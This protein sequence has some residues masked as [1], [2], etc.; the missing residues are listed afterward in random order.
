M[1]VRS[2]G[3]RVLRLLSL[4]AC[5]SFAPQ[6]SRALPDE[7]PPPAFAGTKVGQVRDDNRLGMKLIWCPAGR[8]KMGT[9]ADQPR[10]RTQDERQ[11]DVTFASGFWLGSTELTQAQWELVM[12]STPW[13]GKKVKVKE[14]DEYPAVYVSWDEAVAYCE[15]LTDQE[16]REGHL[17]D[18]SHYTLPTEAEWEYACRAGTTTLFSFGDDNSKL[19]DYGW[20]R[21]YAGRGRSSPFE[22]YFH[23]VAQK[24]PNP[25]GF[26]DMHG[27]VC[28]WC[29]DLYSEKLPGGNDPE[30]VKATPNPVLE[31]LKPHMEVENSQG[32]GGAVR[33]YRGGYFNSPT[34]ACRSASRR[35]TDVSPRNWFTGFRI[36]LERRGK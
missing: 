12:G 6:A 24:K 2:H 17:P 3:S 36:A 27:N 16:K 35:R 34:D 33:V 11:V 25:W 18:H 22:K 32:S 14:G 13:Q 10:L 23:P 4:L 28:E 31:K 8:F 20:A 1:P 29:R 9:P 30:V 26:F 15:K 5:L 21:E 7:H 19:A